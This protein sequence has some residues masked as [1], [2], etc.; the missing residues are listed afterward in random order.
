MVHYVEIVQDE[1]L[2]PVQNSGLCSG[3]LLGP[4][5]VLTARHCIP[6]DH[7][8]VR[9]DMGSQRRSSERVFVHPRLD[10]ALILL[11]QPMESQHDY[12]VYEGRTSDLLGEPVTCYGYGEAGG[13]G[14]AGDLRMAVLP[15]VSVGGTSHF[16][17]APNERGQS[18]ALGDSGG[19]CILDPRADPRLVVGIFVDLSAG[20]LSTAAFRLWIQRAL[21]SRPDLSVPPVRDD[22]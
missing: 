14:S 2:G 22:Q 16:S 3:T 20:N 11:E 5:V 15:V 10:V 21:G 19:P 17:T 7:N 12:R 6:K 4:R 13:V 9:I 8:Q 18:Q 1:N